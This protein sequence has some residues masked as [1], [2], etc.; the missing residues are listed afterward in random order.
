MNANAV[1][2]EK[3]DELNLPLG[4]RPISPAGNG[5]G[6]LEWQMAKWFGPWTVILMRRELMR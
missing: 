3:N 4:K 6:R 1:P 5:A 2:V